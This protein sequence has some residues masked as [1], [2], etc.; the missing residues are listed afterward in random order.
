MWGKS[1]LL[2]KKPFAYADG[3]F[4]FSGLAGDAAFSAFTDATGSA[5]FT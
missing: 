1:L 5:F 3:F 2:T 4:A